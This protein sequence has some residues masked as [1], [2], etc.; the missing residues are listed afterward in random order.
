M[1]IHIHSSFK[2][3]TCKS[4]YNLSRS[5]I[6]KHLIS[7]I[8]TFQVVGKSQC[9]R[10]CYQFTSCSAAS[11]S[12]KPSFK[13][14]QAQNKRFFRPDRAVW[15]PLSHSPRSRCHTP[16]LFCL[17]RPCFYR[18]CESALISALLL[19]LSSAS[20]K[21]LRAPPFTALQ[22]KSPPRRFKT[23]AVVWPQNKN[24]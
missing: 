10:R 17:E 2:T 3:S 14:T 16:P 6:V 9:K 20:R 1:S 15:G 7:V 24:V 12:C 11:F 4:I 8:S 5:M 22:N 21:S 18:L 13:H 19:P 23:K